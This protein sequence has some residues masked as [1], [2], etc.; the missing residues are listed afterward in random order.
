MGGYKAA[1]W[2]TRQ[3]GFLEGV[4]QADSCCVTSDRTDGEIDGE[5]NRL[6]NHVAGTISGMAAVY[7]RQQFLDKRK[8]ALEARAAH[9]ARLNISG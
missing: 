6:L 2:R 7:Q 9:V 1:L 8:A 5:A 4:E 3:G